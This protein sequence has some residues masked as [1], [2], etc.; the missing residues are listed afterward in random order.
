MGLFDISENYFLGYDDRK[1]F[2]N[3]LQFG[4]LSNHIV[5]LSAFTII[6]RYQL[7]S[8][9][10]FG[11]YFESTMSITTLVMD[12]SEL[13]N[14]QTITTFGEIIADDSRK[15]CGKRRIS[16]L[17]AFFFHIDLKPLLSVI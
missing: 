17:R 8:V 15:Y 9:D 4:L 14:Y 2:N 3:F 12:Q 5:F 7:V 11:F 16:L 6:S 1:C 10:L 13:T